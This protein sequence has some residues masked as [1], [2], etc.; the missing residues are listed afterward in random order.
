MVSIFGIIELVRRGVFCLESMRLDVGER[1]H[2]KGYLLSATSTP[3]ASAL[4][5]QV[6]Y[7]TQAGVYRSIHHPETQALKFRL[8]PDR[9]TKRGPV[10]KLMTR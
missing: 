4:R 10:L 7:E 3:Q 2:R 6:M 1:R 5:F 9:I 8:T